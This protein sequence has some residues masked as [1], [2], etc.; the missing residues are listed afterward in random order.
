M[1]RASHLPARTGVGFKPA[2]FY[3]ILAAPQPLGFFEV[4]A[5]NYMGAGGP[6][7]AQLGALRER[8]ALS[9]HGVG[10]SIG[11]TRPLDRDHLARLKTLCD[12]Y[13]PESFSEHLAWSSHDGIY[14]NDLL[15]LPYTRRTLAR[16]AEHVD[17]VQSAL[18]R[19]M[20]LENPSTYVRFSESNI[21]EVDFIA[22]LSKRTGCGLLLDVNNVFVSARNHATEP[23]AY[24]DSFP[25]ERVK[26]IH[27]G[28]HDV[29]V[30]D[31]GV[32]LLIDSHGSP[33]VEDVWM[34]Y[35]HVVARAGA[36]PTLIE[37]DND[38]PDW[39]GLLAEAVR[40][41]GVLSD[42]ACASAA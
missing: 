22:E 30:D 10:L 34:L 28:G 4:H 31:A 24:L 37:W 19:Q 2:H 25:L 38:V 29:D 33:I 15:P 1:L 42:Q 39:P 23:L 11:S 41:Q 27:L 5:E 12:R 3:D 40:A 6:P 20:L 32:P 26:E 18:G 36:L 13:A 17:E 8:Y 16:V 14:L 35:A 21:P 9:V 7:H